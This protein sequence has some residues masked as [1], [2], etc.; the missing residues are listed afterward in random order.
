MLK[1]LI[2]DREQLIGK[3]IQLN[4]QVT[5]TQVDLKN[6]TIKVLEVIGKTELAD[7]PQAVEHEIAQIK[8]IGSAWESPP[9][10]FQDLL[11]DA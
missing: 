11:E 6:N 2:E 9:R 5:T 4:S 3:L 7:R 8:A 1:Q 10:A